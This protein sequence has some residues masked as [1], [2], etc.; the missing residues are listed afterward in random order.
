MLNLTA[1]KTGETVLDPFCG[2]GTLVQE[3]LLL[4]L[5][6]IGSDINKVAIKGSEQNLEWF[7]NRYKIAPGKYGLETCD[8]TK[9]ADLIGKSGQKIHAIATESTLGPIYGQYP[10]PEEIVKN[11]KALQKLYTE[12]FKEFTKFLPSKGRVVMCI[13][14]YRKSQ[15]QYEMFPTLDFAATLGYKLVDIISPSVVKKLKFLKL[16]ARNT[17]IYDRKDQIVAREIVIF[18]KN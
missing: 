5:R 18:E 1:C 12:S 11:F 3:G 13:P 14:A 2:V 16:T 6:M 7:R 9:V 10:K 4:G 15:N 8:A 17:A